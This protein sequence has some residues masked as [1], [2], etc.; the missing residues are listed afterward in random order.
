MKAKVVGISSASKYV[1]NKV[2]ITLQFGDADAFSKELKV[3]EDMLPFKVKLDDEVEF[4]VIPVSQVIKI[5][6]EALPTVGDE[7]IINNHA[8]AVMG[9]K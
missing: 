9:G 7:V 3:T 6:E 2:R 4:A 5:R 8:E 1:D